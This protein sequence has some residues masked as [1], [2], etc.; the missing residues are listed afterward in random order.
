MLDELTLG[1]LQPHAS[2]SFLPRTFE[3]GRLS[4]K[5]LERGTSLGQAQNLVRLQTKM[6]RGT[7]RGDAGASEGVTHAM[8]LVA[9]AL[10]E[11]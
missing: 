6:S 2:P 8:E 7:V 5:R 9:Y 4:L 3:A 1:K 10:G 11:T